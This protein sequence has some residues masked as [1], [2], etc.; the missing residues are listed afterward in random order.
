MRVGDTFRATLSYGSTTPM[1]AADVWVPWVASVGRKLDDALTGRRRRKGADNAW[2]GDLAIDGRTT[3]DGTF[4]FHGMSVPPC[5]MI[6]VPRIWD[7]LRRRARE[8]SADDR[9]I[10]SRGVSAGR[11]MPGRRASANS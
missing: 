9:S 3:P 11:W 1:P 5:E 6:V 8:A 2:R 10:G 7:D 4:S